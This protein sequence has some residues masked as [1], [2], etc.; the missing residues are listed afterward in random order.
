MS[1]EI[2]PEGE[3]LEVEYDRYD[4]TPTPDYPN[5]EAWWQKFCLSGFDELEK[6]GLKAK[7]L[8]ELNNDAYLAMAVNHF[9][10]KN[11]KTWLDKEGIEDLG[12]LTPRQCLSSDYGMKR[13]RMLFL[14]SH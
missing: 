5:A 12:G 8:K 3:G 11:H 6:S 13:L 2:V 14:T 9:V 4:R 7:L 1:N 10:G